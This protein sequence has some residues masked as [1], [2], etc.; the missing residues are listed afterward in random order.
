MAADP[1][2]FIDVQTIQANHRNTRVMGQVVTPG[3][4]TKY[5]DNTAATNT[6][7]RA[8]ANAQD[9]GERTK[10]AAVGTDTTKGDGGF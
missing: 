7:V 8:N 6:A 5:T 10:D 3:K 1:V 2:G 4:N 9:F